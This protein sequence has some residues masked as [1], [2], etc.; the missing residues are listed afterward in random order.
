[1]GDL[2]PWVRHTSTCPKTTDRSDL[3]K[4]GLDTALID[5]RDREIAGIQGALR[6]IFVDGG[7]GVGGLGYAEALYDA[8][9]RRR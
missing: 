5:D 8:G 3:C 2:R 4:C 1:M 9:L 6:E 7:K